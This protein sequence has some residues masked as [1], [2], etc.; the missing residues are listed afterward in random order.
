VSAT[1]LSRRRGRPPGSRN[2]PPLETH[3]VRS[4][5]LEPITVRVAEAASLLGCGIS[6]MKR[7]IADGA[8]ESVKV[9]TMRLVKVSSLRRLVGE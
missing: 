1:Q 8:V 7:L 4:S 9:G 2:K 5:G 3:V 6:K